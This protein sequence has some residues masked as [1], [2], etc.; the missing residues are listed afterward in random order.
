MNHKFLIREKTKTMLLSTI[1]R[2]M[3]TNMYHITKKLDSLTV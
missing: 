2:C 1:W 3:H